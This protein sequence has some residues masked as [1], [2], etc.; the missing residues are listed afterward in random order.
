M[1]SHFSSPPPEF[2]RLLAAP[3]SLPCLP[4]PLPHSLLPTSALRSTLLP[5]P[6]TE[7]WPG[8]WP[9][10]TVSWGDT[11]GMAEEEEE[12]EEEEEGRGE[13]GA[14]IL[15]QVVC[16]S[17]I[18]RCRNRRWGGVCVLVHLGGVGRAFPPL[19]NLHPLTELHVVS[20]LLYTKV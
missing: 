7:W 19:A 17:G 9:V 13:E 18:W 12:E 1:F 8:R 11:E 20:D 10:W 14:T 2:F 4:A 5:S 6:P 15:F 3:Q 16:L